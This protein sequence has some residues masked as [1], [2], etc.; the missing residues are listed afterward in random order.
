MPMTVVVEAPTVLYRAAIS[1]YHIQCYMDKSRDAV[2]RYLKDTHTSKLIT[3]ITP[4]RRVQPA[5]VELLNKLRGALHMYVRKIAGDPGMNLAWTKEIVLCFMVQ[6]MESLGAPFTPLGALFRQSRLTLDLPELR[7]SEYDELQRYLTAVDQ[8]SSVVQL[9]QRGLYQV[10]HFN[11]IRQNVVWLADRTVA[12]TYTRVSDEVELYQFTLFPSV[13]LRLLNLNDVATARMMMRPGFPFASGKTYDSSLYV[14][15]IESGVEES[16]TSRIAIQ[17]EPYEEQMK[18]FVE[19]WMT[20]ETSL[21]PAYEQFKVDVGLSVAFTSEDWSY[22]D[23]KNRT[24][25]DTRYHG[26]WTEVVAR[27]EQL[28]D[29]SGLRE[30]AGEYNWQGLFQLWNVYDEWKAHEP[31][32]LRDEFSQRSRHTL[33]RFVQRLSVAFEGDLVKLTTLV[34]GYEVNSPGQLAAFRHELSEHWL[35]LFAVDLISPR[36]VWMLSQWFLLFPEPGVVER[37]SVFSG[38]TM[39]VYELRTSQWLKDKRLDGWQCNTPYEVMLIEPQ[40]FGVLE[41]VGKGYGAKGC[42]FEE[43]D[44]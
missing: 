24:V 18:P 11:S 28:T 25:I 38:D 3:L 6:A 4:R 33:M 44:S 1:L 2:D 32:Q 29:V 27:V 19:D 20:R 5:S 23:P 8:C 12:K 7:E 22:V 41:R 34:Q 43:D 26:E 9:A 17:W 31:Q 40:K 42:V 35:D 16:R 15:Y 39:M 13:K 10:E 37:C 30:Q 14:H 21:R 36:G